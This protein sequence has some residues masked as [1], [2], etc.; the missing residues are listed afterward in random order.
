MFGFLGE[1]HLLVLLIH[2][3]HKLD[4]FTLHQFEIIKH[5]KENL[6]R[7]GIFQRL[8]SFHWKHAGYESSQALTQCPVAFLTHDE[9]YS[10]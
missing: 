6:L 8:C 2:L 3:E 1:K 7:P 5:R 9:L 4:I 10:S